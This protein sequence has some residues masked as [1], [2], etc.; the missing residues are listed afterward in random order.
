MHTTFDQ[1]GQK[2]CTYIDDER[3]LSLQFKKLTLHA[4][5][6]LIGQTKISL[7]DCY[8]ISTIVDIDSILLSWYLN[9]HY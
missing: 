5:F 3:I 8:E 7:I 9:N 4:I 6:D 1:I 2:S